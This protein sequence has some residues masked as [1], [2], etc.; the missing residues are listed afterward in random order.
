M[1]TIYQLI[2]C[3][4]AFFIAFWLSWDGLGRLAV[5]FAMAAVLWGLCKGLL[6]VWRRAKGLAAGTPR[7]P[8]RRKG[9]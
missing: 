5:Y 2:V 9:W 6:G 8:A 3:V 4:V 1:Q 7:L